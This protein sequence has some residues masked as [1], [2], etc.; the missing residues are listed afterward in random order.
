LHLAG[1][2][3]EEVIL[4][5]YRC[6]FSISRV[7]TVPSGTDINVDELDKDDEVKPVILRSFSPFSTIDRTNL[8]SL[9]CTWRGSAPAPFKLTVVR[10]EG[11]RHYYFATTG[12]DAEYEREEWLC[13]FGEAIREVTCSLFPPYQMDAR[14]LP[15]VQTT[16]TRIM[17]GYLLR[18]EAADTLSLLYC[19][20]HAYFHGE[21]LLILYKDA[22]CD[23]KVCTVHLKGEMSV[24]SCK[25]VDCSMFAVDGHLFAARTQ[26]ERVLWLRA[27]GN[28][29]VKIM[30]GAPD[31][32]EEELA[33]FRE[34]VLSASALCK[35]R[36]WR[37]A[38]QSTR[39]CCL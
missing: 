20:L 28:I 30:F 6:G 16:T 10:A 7:P 19:E 4:A 33:A 5:V 24:H 35:R 29:K 37:Q 26:D 18:C 21:A 14:P 27:V 32:T 17:A 9:K 22:W 12:R 8:P 1:G 3:F 15:G 34:A 31:P 38:I 39:P 11:D 25:G 23:Q 36:T 13:A 2:Y